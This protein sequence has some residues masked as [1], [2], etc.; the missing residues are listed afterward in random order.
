MIVN[1]ANAS[2]PVT[3]ESAINLPIEAVQS[4]EV[5]TNPYAAEYGEFTSGVTS[6]Q[7][8]SGSD[9][10]APMQPAFPKAT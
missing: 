3:G 7:T 8:R 6:V 4:V 5:L 2:D 1:S 10:S 9:R